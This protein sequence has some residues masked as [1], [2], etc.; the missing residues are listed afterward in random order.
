MSDETEGCHA[1]GPRF[2]V[3]CHDK[4][5]PRVSHDCW[6]MKKWNDREYIA[7]EVPPGAHQPAG[8]TDYVV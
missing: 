5:D 8:T 2:C 7:E 6:V 1:T 3:H 4:I